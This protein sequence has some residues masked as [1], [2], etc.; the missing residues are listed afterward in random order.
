M[1]GLFR[2]GNSP[3]AVGLLFGLLATILAPFA[4]TQPVSAELMFHASRK[5]PPRTRIAEPVT[6]AI[7]SQNSTITP[8][9]SQNLAPTLT[10]SSATSAPEQIPSV[11][12]PADIELPEPANPPTIQ[13]STPSPN[14]AVPQATVT[15]VTR[16]KAEQAPSKPKP[17]ET[18]QKVDKNQHPV[19]HFPSPLVTEADTKPSSDGA[20]ERPPKE[21]VHKAHK[22]KKKAAPLAKAAKKPIEKKADQPL[23]AAIKKGKPAT[24]TVEVTEK[25]PPA[26]AKP[27]AKI[28][29]TVPAPAKPSA[30]PKKQE[31]ALV[32]FPVD[33][34]PVDSATHT[35]A[36]RKQ[37]AHIYPVGYHP[38]SM[39][40]NDAQ[41]QNLEA[42]IT[43]F[44]RA[45][46]YGRQNHL[47]E[48]LAEYRQALHLNPTLADAY[49]GLST[50]S[51]RK[52]DWET[53]IESAEQALKMKNGFLDSANIAQ[54]QF[55]LS[56]AYCV[57]DD[58]R[59]AKRYYKKTQKQHHPDSE[60]LSF[61]LQ[62]YCKR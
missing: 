18:I 39:P 48:A 22:P 28:T 29:A 42:A 15:S 10:E 55:N 31:K 21:L 4:T 11:S 45:G 52:N 34:Q 37:S 14:Q 13:A 3:V 20:K 59:K 23:Q 41:R 60:R 5:I 7:P 12:Q 47:D 46:Y 58:Y 49:V 62:K 30:K 27:Q 43:H 36:K 61:Y 38:Y 33:L 50:V 1:N 51:M 57:T 35:A 2:R 56:T 54:A 9:S 8:S 53:V 44:N 16:P 17:V 40:I 6:K 26:P 25:N 19:V 24:G 32:H